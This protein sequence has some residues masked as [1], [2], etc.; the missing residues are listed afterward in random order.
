MTNPP[1]DLLSSS[2]LFLAVYCKP[3]PTWPWKSLSFL[4][5]TSPTHSPQHS[6]VWLQPLLAPPL[7]STPPSPT[8]PLAES[9]GAICG[10][11]T[12]FSPPGCYFLSTAAKK[13]KKSPG[14]LTQCLSL[15]FSLSPS[16]FTGLVYT[17]VHLARGNAHLQEA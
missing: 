2:R 17:I 4:L 9:V 15:S 6:S 1:A 13:K 7:P 10:G 12:T 8:D 14:L 11:E 5:P 16:C 3:R